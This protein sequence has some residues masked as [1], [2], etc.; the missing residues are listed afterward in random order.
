MLGAIEIDALRDYDDEFEP[1]LDV[2][3]AR[4]VLWAIAVAAAH[5]IVQEASN[6]VVRLVRAVGEAVRRA[7][8]S[9]RREAPEAKGRPTRRDQVLMRRRYTPQQIAAVVS[10]L[11]C[12][13]AEAAD[14]ERAEAVEL[15]LRR[16]FALVWNG[17]EAVTTTSLAEFD[18]A[19]LG[20]L[21]A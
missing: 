5:G 11:A 2:H 14:L 17:R 7:P 15:F 3:P 12:N 13:R 16:G 18:A 19:R 21:R 8:A 10:A 1:D 20:A 6:G 9:A 4:I